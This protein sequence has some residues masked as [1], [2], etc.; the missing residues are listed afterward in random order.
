MRIS[1]PRQLPAAVAL[2]AVG[3]GAI[4][5]YAVIARRHRAAEPD[6]WHSVTINCSPERLDPLPPP[7]DELDFPVEVRIQPAP[8]DRGTELAARV[9]SGADRE[10][11]RRLRRALREARSIAETGE[12]LLPDAPATTKPTLRSAPLAYATKHG[13]EEGRL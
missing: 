11:V 13:R 6:R 8:G 3:A 12:V 4:A 10:R 7:L 9:T 1:E 5:G 2:T